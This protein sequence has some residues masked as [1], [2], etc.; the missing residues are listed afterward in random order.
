[1]MISLDDSGVTPK[2]RQTLFLKSIL[3]NI[4]NL[5]EGLFGQTNKLPTKD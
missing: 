5:S 1:M 3:Q 2:Y 4:K